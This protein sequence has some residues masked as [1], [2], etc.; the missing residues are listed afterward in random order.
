MPKVIQFKVVCPECGNIQAYHSHNKEVEGK[1]RKECQYC[2]RSFIAT[3]QRLKDHGQK[4]KKLKEEMQE[5]GKGFHKYSKS[6][7]GWQD[8]ED[9]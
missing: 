1:R 2:G 9:D 7:K 8:E 5:K 3:D 6:S 4:K